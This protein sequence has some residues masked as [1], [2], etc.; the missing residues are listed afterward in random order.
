MTESGKYRWTMN[1]IRDFYS[2]SGTLE[3]TLEY[4]TAEVKVGQPANLDKGVNIDALDLELGNIAVLSDG[5][6]TADYI[7]EAFVNI[8]P[9]L[10]RKPI[11]DALEN[12]MKN[13]IQEEVRKALDIEAEIEKR[14]PPP[15]PNNA[16][17]EENVE[18]EGDD[19]E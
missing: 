15:S 1:V 12:P 7:I 17:G 14:L 9:N 16:T 8:V 19:E 10:L 11:I 6:G 5:V 13:M 18:G 4:I 3:F 2:I